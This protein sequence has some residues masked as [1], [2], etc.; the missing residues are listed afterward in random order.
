MK[1]EFIQKMQN[2][3]AETSIGASAL[4]NQGVKDLIQPCRDYCKKI[5]LAAIPREPQNFASWLNRKTTA[6]M[7]KVPK[8]A[9]NNFGAARKALNLFLRSSAYNC[10]LNQA[11]QLDEMLPLLEVPL[12]SYVG[13][14]LRRDATNRE[15]PKWDRLKKIKPELHEQFQQ[16]ANVVAQ[17]KGVHRADLDVYYY[18]KKDS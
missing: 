13:K 12:D 8:E 7:Y 9:K 2:F 5:D 16:A 3:V 15:L 1:E 11:Y 18:R 6:L 14:G 17:V 10:C 4:R